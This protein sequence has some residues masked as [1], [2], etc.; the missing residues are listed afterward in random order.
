MIRGLYI[1]TGQS[2]ITI[3]GSPRTPPRG[4]AKRFQAREN[5]GKKPAGSNIPSDS[6]YGPTCCRI[7]PAMTLRGEHA[8]AEMRIAGTIPGELYYPRSSAAKSSL[9]SSG[10]R[11][12][13][14]LTTWSASS[15]IQRNTPSLRA[16][17]CD[18]CLRRGPRLIFN[19]PSRMPATIRLQQ[20]PG[21]AGRR[22]ASAGLP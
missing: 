16:D 22:Q 10:Q 17:G 5:A 11:I 20:P 13:K 3:P 4:A 15:A 12:G 19:G 1:A 21:I 14:E 6:H 18:Q 8:S 7:G 2:G 9:L